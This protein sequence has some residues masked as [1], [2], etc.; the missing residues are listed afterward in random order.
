MTNHQRLIA[1]FK[2]TFDD[3]SL[4]VTDE[5]SPA[6]YELW[7]SVETVNL[8]MAI[9]REFGVRFSTDEV[10]SI[11]DFKSLSVLVQKHAK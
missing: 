10:A 3:D 9:E 11:K 2:E 5:I 1:L 6:N 8:L 4:E 7:D